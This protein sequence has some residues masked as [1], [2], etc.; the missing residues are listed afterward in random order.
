M[1]FDFWFSKLIE[2]ETNKDHIEYHKKVKHLYR[3]AWNN[4][5]T[6]KGLE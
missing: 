5:I 2:G 3:F 4:C 6:N 1:T